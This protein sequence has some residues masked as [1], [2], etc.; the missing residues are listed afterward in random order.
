M[1]RPRKPEAGRRNRT[2][3][4]RVTTAPSRPSKPMSGHR[5]SRMTQPFA[6]S[7]ISAT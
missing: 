6:T 2:I 7:M 1:V 3:C 5:S 4:V